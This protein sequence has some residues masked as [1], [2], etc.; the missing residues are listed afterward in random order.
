MR[1]FGFI[2]AIDRAGSGLQQIWRT[3]NSEFYTQPMLEE[4]YVPDRVILT[5]PLVKEHFTNSARAAKQTTKNAEDAAVKT[6]SNTS[7]EVILQLLATEDVVTAQLVHE[8]TG[9]SVRRSQEMLKK[10][11]DDGLV[12]REK[13]GRFLY[14]LHTAKH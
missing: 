11:Y 12:D 10:F 5:L 14:Y 4:S 2:G 1:I 8:V 7:E 13:E 3:W 6:I 9:L